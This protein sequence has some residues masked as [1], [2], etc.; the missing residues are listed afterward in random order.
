MFDRFVKHLIEKPILMSR[1]EYEMLGFEDDAD[2]L[3]A[4]ALNRLMEKNG[5]GR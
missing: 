2:M 4:R 5:H 3:I 1:A